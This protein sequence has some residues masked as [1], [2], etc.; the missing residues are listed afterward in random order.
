MVVAFTARL[1][2]PIGDFLALD[3]AQRRIRPSFT[4]ELEVFE[5]AADFIQHGSFLQATPGRHQSQGGN[6]VSLRFLGGN[7][8][9]FRFDQ[10]VTWRVGLVQGRLSAEP[11]ILGTTARFDVDDRAQMDLVA[12]ERNPNAIGPREQVEN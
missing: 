2:K 4:T 6:A 5:M 1:L 10:T 9:W 11:A 12:F 8:Q 3:H 7:P